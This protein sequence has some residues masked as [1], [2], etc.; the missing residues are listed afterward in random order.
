MDGPLS[1]LFLFLPDDTLLLDPPFLL[2]FSGMENPG[3][4]ASAL[5][6]PGRQDSNSFSSLLPSILSFFL[7]CK[8]DVIDPCDSREFLTRYEDLARIVR[9]SSR[10]FFSTSEMP[11]V[12]EGR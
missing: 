9:T 5:L 2:L 10:P 6:T 11:Q 7:V 4:A 12:P 8:F 1:H 3:W